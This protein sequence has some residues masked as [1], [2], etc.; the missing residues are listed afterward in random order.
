[1][2]RERRLI[3]ELQSHAFHSSPRAMASD[4]ARTRRLLLAGW[5]VIYVTWAQLHRRGDADALAADL[6]AAL[7]LCEIRHRDWPASQFAL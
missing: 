6:R 2:W 1:L 3:V 7:A 4:A 5:R